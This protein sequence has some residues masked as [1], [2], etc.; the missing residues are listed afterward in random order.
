MSNYE[1][2]VTD[3]FKIQTTDHLNLSSRFL[4]MC[5]CLIFFSFVI[6]RGETL[7]VYVSK[8]CEW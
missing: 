4:S 6:A 1:M 2:P 5:V 7:I 8:T 3:D